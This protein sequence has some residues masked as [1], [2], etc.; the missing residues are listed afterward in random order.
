VK[1]TAHC[2]VV[3]FASCVVFAQGINPPWHA[4][5]KVVDENN[6][7]VEHATVAI[8]YY[9]QPPPGETE[10]HDKIEGLT[11]TNGLFA[12]SNETNNSIDLGFQV[13]KAGYYP[14]RKGHEFAT[15]KDNDPQKWNP[16]ET[17]QLK[18]I[19][20]PIAMYAKTITYLRFPVLNKPIGYDL[21]IG[22]WV[23]PYGKG[24]T[25]DILFA[26][27]HTNANSGYTFAVS[28]PNPGDGIQGFTRDWNLGVSGLLS[29][30]EAPLDGRD[31][32]AIVEKRLVEIHYAACFKVSS[33]EF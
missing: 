25:T 30:H 29:S 33:L 17:L 11:D 19:G 3:L 18:K 26:E 24:T 23:G 27:N 12:A 5:V 14:T 10:A 6:Q 21:M 32:P 22:D 8:W 13:S 4:T 2:L 9:V 20:K 7:P 28:F 1:K 16:T 15:F 31:V